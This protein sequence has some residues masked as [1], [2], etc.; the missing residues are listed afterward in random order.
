MAHDPT[1]PNESMQESAVI[2]G[3]Q[4]FER[5]REAAAARARALKVAE[6]ERKR[7]AQKRLVLRVLN[8][9]EEQK[10]PHL[11]LVT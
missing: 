7:D 1:T 10:S 2:Q 3:E 5:R 4:I 8:R 6:L 9:N 11:R